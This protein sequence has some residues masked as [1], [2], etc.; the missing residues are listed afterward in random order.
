[1]PWRQHGQGAGC[2]GV[3]FVGAEV[4]CVIQLEHP[5]RPWQIGMDQD[6]VRHDCA[7]QQIPCAHRRYHVLIRRWPIRDRA[8]IT[9]FASNS[10]CQSSTVFCHCIMPSA[11]IMFRMAHDA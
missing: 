2:K 11:L 7:C 1:M 9:I 10:R 4:E 3:E 8:A 5:I 6:M